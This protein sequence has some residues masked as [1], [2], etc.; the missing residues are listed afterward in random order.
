MYKNQILPNRKSVLPII[1]QYKTTKSR[2]NCLAKFH[3]NRSR[4]S[5][6]IEVIASSDLE[7]AVL[8]LLTAGIYKVRR[9]DDLRWNY[10]LIVHIFSFKCKVALFYTIALHVSAI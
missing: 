5:S 1:F 8:V 9:S 2:I 10:I 3:D 6:N 7:A 4:H